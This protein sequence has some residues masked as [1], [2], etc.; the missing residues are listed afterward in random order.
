VLRTVEDKVV[1]VTG[2]SS[3]IGAAT[4]HAFGQLGAQV[5]LAARRAEKLQAEA[6]LIEGAGGRALACPTD[7]TD[8]EEVSRLLAR[9]RE[10]LGPVDI[11]VN[12]AGVNWSRALAQTTPE[13][14]AH[15]VRVNLIGAMQLTSAVLPEML[16]RGT[17]TV[18]SV[19]SVAGHVAI[20]PLYSSTK[21]GLR[22]FS[23]ALRRQLAGSGVSICLVSPGNIRTQM[24]TGIGAELPGPEMAA[25]TI[26]RLAMRPRREVVVPARYRGLIW[27]DELA[28]T[29]ADLAFR[30]RRRHDPGGNHGRL[31][32]YASS[33]SPESWTH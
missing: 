7:V 21:F 18:I 6:S 15:A 27:L 1:I 31:P 17:G 3:G 14:I 32:A 12:N 30:W 29:V 22:G 13:E 25:Q 23:L 9:T 10:T 26:V 8:M 5:V 4:A 11:L 24:T 19:G 33:S 16:E 28:P 2:A 20:E